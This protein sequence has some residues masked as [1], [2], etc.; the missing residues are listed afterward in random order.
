MPSPLFIAHTSDGQP[1]VKRVVLD[2]D[3][4][5]TVEGI[6]VDQ[7]DAF[8]RD[9]L[10][11]IPFVREY[12]PGADEL[13]IIPTDQVPGVEPFL[14][15]VDANPLD[16]AELGGD[17]PASINTKALFVK[18][19]E[20]VLVQKFTIGQV[21]SRRFL[22][23]LQG[24][25]YRR[26]VDTTFALGSSLAFV[27]EDGLIKFRNLQNM[28]SIM[29]MGEV[30]RA[31]TEADVRQFADHPNF[32]I[33]DIDNFVGIVD[34]PSRKIIGSI[35]GSALLDNFGPEV[36][37]RAAEETGLTIKMQDN[38]IVIPN[39]RR[40]VKTLLQFL[41][42]SRYVGPLTGIPLIANSKRPA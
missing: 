12:R 38:R 40:E 23:G 31:A 13:F 14:D 26:V 19:D 16:I 29:E 27:V 4:Q 8:T 15:A 35:I 18:V 21:L 22:L 42:E 2:A 24:N 10:E 33:D 7:H 17:N 9:V 25:A 28:R 20:R 41:D 11:E 32:L 39:D 6:F 34:Q 36:I 30:Y 3:I 5:G 1:A 37:Q